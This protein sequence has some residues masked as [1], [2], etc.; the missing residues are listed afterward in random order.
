MS[1]LEKLAAAARDKSAPLPTEEQARRTS[2]NA[3]ERRSVPPPLPASIPD[4]PLTYGTS[5]KPLTRLV[6]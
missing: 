2:E 1:D 4:V 3:S 5:E 6:Y